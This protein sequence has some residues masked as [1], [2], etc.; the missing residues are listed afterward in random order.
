MFYIFIKI[1]C[2]QDFK[3]ST[4]VILYLIL[5]SYYSLYIIIIYKLEWLISGLFETSWTY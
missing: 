4:I 3:Y 5:N 2:Y 1:L